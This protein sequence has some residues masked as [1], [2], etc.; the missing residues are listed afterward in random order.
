MADARGF[1]SYSTYTT[2]GPGSGVGGTAVAGLVITN[3]AGGAISNHGGESI[4]G[5]SYANA[6]ASGF[7]ATGGTAIASTVITNSAALHS[8]WQD[9]IQG[10]AKAN[11][12]GYSDNSGGNATGGTAIAS[13]VISN[14]TT[15]A[16]LFSLEHSGIDGQSYALANAGTGSYSLPLTA[17]AGYA[18]ATTTI[19]NDA[20]I[21]KEK[22]G[23]FGAAT[24]NASA[25]ATTSSGGSAFG[26]TAIAGVV[27]SNSGTILDALNAGPDFDDGGGIKGRSSATANASGFTAVG[28]IASATTTIVNAPAITVELTAITGSATANANA[29]GVDVKGSSATGGTAVAVTVI[30]NGTADALSSH[31]GSGIDGSSNA[32]AN[33]GE[34]SARSYTATGGFATAGT[35]ISNS[36]SI[37]SNDDAIVGNA[38]ANANAYGSEHV[39]A[40]YS[41]CAGSDDDIYLWRLRRL[42]FSPAKPAPTPAMPIPPAP[43]SVP[44]PPPAAPRSRAC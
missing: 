35:Q 10:S 1:G 36:S 11:A 14:N 13:V 34:Y 9:T 16:T 6:F 7:T 30:S 5:Y 31:S 26:G 27:I 8:G 22:N 44:A 17:V 23:I 19:T 32:S 20:S 12:S 43:I 2:T 3:N 28:G 40:I 25:Y 29:Y 42:R 39:H 38:T 33:A 41:Y 21:L 4:D 24:A 37:K 15:G 18:Q